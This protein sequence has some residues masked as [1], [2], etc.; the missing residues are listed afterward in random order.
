MDAAGYESWIRTNDARHARQGSD[1]VVA[2]IFVNPAQF[3]PTEDLGK[4]PR[5]M[6]QDI[7]LLQKVGTDVI[8]APEVKEMYPSGIVLDVSQQSGTFV[9]VK[10]KSHQME[11]MIRPHFFRGVA[12]V[13]T[14]LFNIIQ[15]TKA[16]FGQKDGQQ[17]AVVRSMV[18]DLFIPTEVVICETIREP[19]GLAM[20]SRNRYLSEKDRNAAPILYK[21]LEAAQKQYLAGER[22][23]SVLV[24]T[25]KAIIA[26][27]PHV[28]LEYV[29]IANP[30]SLAEE[31]VIGDDGGMMCGAV[32]VGATRIIDNVL[33]G[34]EVQKLKE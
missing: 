18:R 20:S 15:P 28:K 19:D 31:E 34:V 1:V 7:S 12:T 33:L 16:F 11:G 21:G 26:T 22:R 25:A 8:F 9:E 24:D 3:A 2:S 13:V 10:G 32:K 4:Y 5:T 23:T 27:E 6:E 17:C 29:S 14:K 30:F